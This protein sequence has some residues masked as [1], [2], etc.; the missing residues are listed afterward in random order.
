LIRNQEQNP[1]FAQFLLER[2]QSG[3]D[4]GLMALISCPLNQISQY[5]ILLERIYKVTPASHADSANLSAATLI[6]KETYKLIQEAINQ[7]SD[8]AKMLDV[9]RR[10]VAGKLE[11]ELVTPE[12]TFLTE[13][14]I[15]VLE[16]KAKYNKHYFIFNDI[17]LLCKA[18]KSQFKPKQVITMKDLII[19]EDLS[20]QMLHPIPSGTDFWSCF[21]L[22][23]PKMKILVMC[24]N[25][26]E[27]M[28][29]VKT[30]KHLV[31]KLNPNTKIFGVSLIELLKRE[32]SVTSIPN[33]L[34]KMVAR[35]KQEIHVEGIFRVSC[36]SAAQTELRDLMEREDDVDF[37]K[38]EV[39]AVTSA[40]K[41]FFREMPEPLLTFILYEDLLVIADDNKEES[42][43]SSLLTI[44]RKLP[45]TNFALLQFLCKFLVSVSQHSESNKMN[46]SNLAIVFGPNLIRPPV[47]SIESTLMMPK[48]NCVVEDMLRHVH[49]LF[50]SN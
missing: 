6:M 1:K 38:F 40:F 48:F 43:V 23:V 32:K 21:H 35:I 47:V 36:S 13:G 8:R 14:A 30:L 27:K 11:F 24:Q 7:S 4:P 5:E 22:I 44:L 39:H 33:F 15:T 12:R 31:D 26:N 16:K 49:K 29:L 9:Q 20:P 28:E 17:L 41:L 42:R 18:H 2:T 37:T 10:L 50:E 19:E 3:D 45:K 46:I 34:E 25:K